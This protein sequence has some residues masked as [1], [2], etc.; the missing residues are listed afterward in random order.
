[1]ALSLSLS[2]FFLSLRL[3]SPLLSC[4]RASTRTSYLGLMAVGLSHCSTMLLSV[5]NR[6]RSLSALMKSIAC[7]SPCL[8]HATNIA[9]L[10]RPI[11]HWPASLSRCA[12]TFNCDR[13]TEGV[14][15]Q[16]FGGPLTHADIIIVICTHTH[17]HT[18]TH[19]LS[20]S[21]SLSLFLSFFL[22]YLFSFLFFLSHFICGCHLFCLFFFPWCHLLRLCFNLYIKFL[23]PFGSYQSF[24]PVLLRFLKPQNQASDI[25]APTS[26]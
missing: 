25:P 10:L 7:C 5:S 12:K 1:M 21:L 4:R 6:P 16:R 23:S 9:I 20:L 18:H 11:K 14:E 15:T 24:L 17:T 8:K 26:A 13:R 19:S 22:S 3:S 2:L